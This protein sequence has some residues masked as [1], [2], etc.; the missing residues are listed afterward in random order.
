MYTFDEKETRQMSVL[1]SARRVLLTLLACFACASVSITPALGA[2]A[3]TA[4]S[5]H[6]KKHHKKKSCRGDRDRDRVEPGGNDGDG[7][8][9]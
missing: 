1:S 8:G 6:H 9:V 4:K 2:S 5:H 7:C 3:Q